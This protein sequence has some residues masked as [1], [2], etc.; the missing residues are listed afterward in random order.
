MRFRFS[1]RTLLIFV[2]VAAVPIAWLGHENGVVQRRIAMRQWV[3][4]HGGY[5]TADPWLIRYLEHDEADEPSAIRRWLG[6]EK[7]SV[8]VFDDDIP[9]ADTTRLETTFPNT[10]IMA[11]YKVPR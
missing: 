3:E 5:C 6:D 2:A 11:L 4:K 9:T 7:V 8:I 1:L 10:V